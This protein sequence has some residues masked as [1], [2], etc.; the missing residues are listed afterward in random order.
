MEKELRENLEKW[1]THKIAAEL[2]HIYII[3]FNARR[4]Q[5]MAESARGC[6]VFSS[7]YT[8]HGAPRFTDDVLSAIFC[9]MDNAHNS[10]LLT[11]GKVNNQSDQ[12]NLKTLIFSPR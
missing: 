10:R 6:C 4:G 3:H 8:I 12:G 11:R 2:A 1:T 5:Y 9:P 7:V